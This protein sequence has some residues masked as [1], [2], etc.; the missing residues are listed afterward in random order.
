MDYSEIISILKEF[1]C[2]SGFRVSIHDTEYNEIYAYPPQISSFCQKIQETDSIKEKCKKADKNAFLK[3]RETDSAYV[4]KCHCGLYEAVAPIYHFGVLSGFLMMGQIRD[5]EPD[6]IEIIKN[7]LGALAEEIGVTAAEINSIKA[8]ESNLIPYYVNIMK[9]V[10][11]HIT[12]TGKISNCGEGLASLVKKY[13]NKNYASKISLSV[14]SR[15]FGCSNSTLMKRFKAEYD[16]TIADYITEVRL[17]NAANLLITS[18]YSVKEISAKCG[19]TDQNYFSRQFSAIYGIS[20]SS[21]RK[22]HL[23]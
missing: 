20:P 3:V 12:A 17:K 6:S 7:H 5:N 1:Y 10:A 11:E 18:G 21:Y 15:K 22:N 8:I 9:M 2:I 4:Y 19:F 14:L 23:G 16:T 13:I